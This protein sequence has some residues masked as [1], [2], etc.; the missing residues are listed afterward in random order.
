M[1]L[2]E[3]YPTSFE[4]SGPL[5]QLAYVHAAQRALWLS[6][7]PLYDTVFVILVLTLVWN[8]RNLAVFERLATDGTFFVGNA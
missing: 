2:D 1:L 4:L 5:K 6:F 3:P 8:N 7:E